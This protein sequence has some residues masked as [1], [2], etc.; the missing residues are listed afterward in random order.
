MNIHVYIYVKKNMGFNQLRNCE[1]TF[2][3]SVGLKEC[4]DFLKG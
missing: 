4:E 3:I 2:K 1:M